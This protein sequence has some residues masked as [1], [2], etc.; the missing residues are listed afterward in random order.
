MRAPRAE[1]YR[2]LV[3]ARAIAT[4]RVPVGMTAVVHEFDAR[5]G[6]SF[7]ISLSYDDSFGVGKTAEHTDTYRGHF[8]ELVPNE[9]I[10]KCS[11]L[12]PP[13]RSYAAR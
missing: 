1:V 12:R 3:D 7:R 5:K 10:V 2:A 6:G 11:S 4:W 9:Q 8:A 13:T